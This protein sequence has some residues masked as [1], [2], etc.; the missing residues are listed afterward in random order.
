M[1]RLKRFLNSFRK[2]KPKPEPPKPIEPTCL[3]TI[4]SNNDPTAHARLQGW[5]DDVVAKHHDF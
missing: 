4:Y 2:S 5:L 3:N 1:N